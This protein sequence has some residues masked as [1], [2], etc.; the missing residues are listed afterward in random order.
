[1]ALV[2]KWSREAEETFNGIIDYLENNWTEKEIKNF[3][4]KT[5]KVIGQIEKNPY[6]FKASSFHEIRKALITKHNSMFYFVNEV[7]G[8][9]ELYA[10]WDNRQD[11]K[12][13]PY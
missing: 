5:H 4:R 2:T 7:D 6:Q 13:S 8:I 9:V 1:M 12:N 3:V 10:F 11:Y